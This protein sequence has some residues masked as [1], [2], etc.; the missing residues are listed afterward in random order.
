M[1]D[2]FYISLPKDVIAKIN[3]LKSKDEKV[4]EFIERIVEEQFLAK[5]VAFSQIEKMQELWDNEK[6]N[7]WDKLE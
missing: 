1:G 2:T 5:E 4:E 6:D 3:K 7:V